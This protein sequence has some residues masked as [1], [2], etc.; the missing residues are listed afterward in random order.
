MSDTAGASQQAPS[1]PVTSSDAPSATTTSITTATTTTN[2]NTSASAAETS[3]TE[4]AIR[5]EP[6]PRTPGH[7]R[8]V[9][10]QTSIDSTG[11]A[12]V[13]SQAS[14]QEYLDRLV[15]PSQG[16][17]ERIAEIQKN[18][19]AGLRRRSREQR[20]SQRRSLEACDRATA[21]ASVTTNGNLSHQPSTTSTRVSIHGKGEKED[22]ARNSKD[23][24]EEKERKESRENKE[25]NERSGFFKGLD[26]L[27]ARTRAATVIQRHYRGYRARREMKGFSIN[28]STRWAHAI[29]EARYREFTRPRA[30]AELEPAPTDPVM[31]VQTHDSTSAAA[32]TGNESLALRNW[33]K[34]T[35]I[36]KHASLDQDPDSDIDE[37]DGD[38]D[39]DDLDS[40][41]DDNT[42]EA[43]A[44]S[45]QRERQRVSAARVRRRKD[46]LIMGLQYFLEMIDVKHRYGANLRVYHEEWKRSDTKEN[47]FYWLD[48][49]EGRLIDTAACPR[50]RLDREQVR[51]LSR[52]ER[53]YYQVKI[54]KEGRLCWAKNGARIDT[55]AKYK[56]SIHGI[57]PVDDPT[58]AFQRVLPTS[59]GEDAA[60]GNSRQHHHH[61]H[62]DSGSASDDSDSESESD[63]S[64]SELV[65]ARAA[66]YTIPDSEEAAGER[67]S[68]SDSKNGAAGMVKKS[69]HFSAATVFD[70]LMRKSVQKNTWIF[71][72][73]TSF[74]LYVGLK[75]SGTF[76][77][78]SFLQGA[79]IS[80]AGLIK[81]R[82]GRL[83]ALS[84]LSGHYRPPVSNFR[85]FLQSLREA[86]A[87]MKHLSISK[88][89]VVLVGLEAYMRTRQRGKKLIQKLTLHG[90]GHDGQGGQA[91]HEK[92]GE[93][94]AT[95]SRLLQ[96]LHIHSAPN[97]I[98]EETKRSDAAVGN[99]EI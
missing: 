6:T 88:A 97:G 40:D 16:E 89:Y 96:K 34:A 85:A 72:A 36:L 42:E 93:G 17:R 79:R 1:Q 45:R 62:Y 49:G 52:E 67:P 80:A 99:M 13:H 55:T 86:G 48:Y 68:T 23:R 33:K 60:H 4:G 70:T 76:Q 81:I 47:F 10:S 14:H 66:K 39:G 57:V 9:A 30:R 24:K 18:K 41:F 2:P 54:D 56:D 15:V 53:Q 51:Y 50:E 26:A 64:E 75:D 87:D 61:H 44:E 94:S 77:H 46:A 90:H 74:R 5:W 91:G 92:D 12:S 38:G 73:D 63:V 78:S 83:M 84:P 82:N 98:E 32:V 29:R 11:H 58:P 22:K 95:T 31:S 37:D 7:H 71:V 69:H 35:E 21:A 19:E 28:A 59:L 8:S 27:V 43:G 20:Q 3:T 65:A 25:G